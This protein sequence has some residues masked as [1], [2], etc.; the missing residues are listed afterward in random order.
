MSVAGAEVVE[1]HMTEQAHKSP[2][3]QEVHAVMPS[4]NSKVSV[5]DG[6]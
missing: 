2:P 5:K 1:A 6:S 3:G 4:D